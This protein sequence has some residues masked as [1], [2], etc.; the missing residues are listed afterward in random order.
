MLRI[1]SSLISRCVCFQSSSHLRRST[2]LLTR[3]FLQRSR[4]RVSVDA[5]DHAMTVFAD[6]QVFI[7]SRPFIIPFSDQCSL[8]L[9]I[10]W[11]RRRWKELISRSGSTTADQLIQNC[12]WLQRECPW[13]RYLI[14]SSQF[15]LGMPFKMLTNSYLIADRSSS[16]HWWTSGM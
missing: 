10:S 8:G 12:T 3:S 7:C 4:Y 5:R 13:K 11:I 14:I 1:G 6:T 15:S 16:D 2:C 9:Q